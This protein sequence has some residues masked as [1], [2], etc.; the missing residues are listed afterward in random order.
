MYI[1]GLQI[2]GEIKKKNREKISE[3]GIYKALGIYNLLL[4]IY[5]SSVFVCGVCVCVC[6]ERQSQR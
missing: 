3:C 2:C 6:I 5:V 1:Y 4:P